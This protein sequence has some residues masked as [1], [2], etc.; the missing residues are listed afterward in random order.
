[1]QPRPRRGSSLKGDNAR[2]SVDSEGFKRFYESMKKS[3]NEIRNWGPE[4]IEQALDSLQLRHHADK[5][6]ESQIDGS[7][8]LDLDEAVLRDLGLSLFEAR[9]L[10]KFVFGWR[11]DALR[12]FLYRQNYRRE[13][14]NPSHW[15]ADMV[16]DMITTELG[17]PELGTFCKE[18]QVNGDLLRDIVIDEELLDYLLT[19]KASKLNA[20][21]L[22]NFVLDGWRPPKRKETHYEA[23]DSQC[24]TSTN[25]SSYEPLSPTTKNASNTYEAPTFW[26]AKNTGLNALE[27]EMQPASKIENAR[28]A[29]DKKGKFEMSTPL[30]T[31]QERSV[32]RE[33]SQE[34]AKATPTGGSVN[35]LMQKYEKKS[36]N[37]DAPRPFTKAV[38]PRSPGESGKSPFVAN[39]KK[40]FNE[41]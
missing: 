10:R 9:K 36:S 23:V 41:K 40:K 15:S 22:K 2:I 21:K 35:S 28:K 26:P 27:S 1:M 17:I 24:E 12:D 29:A 11:P 18:N 8:L 39:M 38:S 31:T 37:I 3:E 16:A 32:S 5:F 33:A 13:S 6:N 25:E 20:V 30:G 7:L 19:G 14:K 4:E 34:K